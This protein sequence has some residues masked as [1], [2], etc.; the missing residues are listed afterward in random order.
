MKYIKF[1]SYQGNCGFDQST[2]Q[3]DFVSPQDNSEVLSLK[4][5]NNWLHTHSDHHSPL[6]D[7][8]HDRSIQD[9]KDFFD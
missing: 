6:K 8:S 2:C 5:A 4:D 7:G 9:M 1:T 3:I